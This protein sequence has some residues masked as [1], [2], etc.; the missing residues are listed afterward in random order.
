MIYFIQLCVKIR[1]LVK[2]DVLS[3]MFLSKVYLKMLLYLSVGTKRFG[4]RNLNCPEKNSQIW[5][6]SEFCCKKG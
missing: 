2:H 4:Q 5:S 3:G 6:D 1:L